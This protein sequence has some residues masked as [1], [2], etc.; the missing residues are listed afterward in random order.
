MSKSRTISKNG[1]ANSPFVCIIILLDVRSPA[2]GGVKQVSVVDEIKARL[3]IVAVVGETVALKKSGR[4]YTGFCP[5]H[6]NTRTPSFV[7]FPDSQT[8]RCFGACADG[9][10][11]FSFIMKREGLDFKEALQFLA[12]RAGVPLQAYA[13]SAEQSE[14]HDKLLDL[15]AAA[16]AYFHHLLTTSPA[17]SKTREYL[18]KRE[19]TGETIATFQ[20]G[21]ALDEWEALK[22][23]LI[24]RGYTAD[25]LLAAGLIVA[26]DDGAPGYDRF[27]HRLMIPIRDSKGRVIGFGARALSTD[28]VP[29]YLNSPQTAL[30][31]KSATL[32]GLDLARKSI[33][34]SGQ[35]VI[36]EGY[37]DTI[38][39]HQRGARNVVAQMGTALTE[40][41]L[42]L[43]A[44]LAQRI[45]LALDADTAGNSATVRSLSVA[46]QLLPKKHRATTTS[47]GVE[48]EAH[49]EQDIYIAALPAGQDPDDVLRA[50]LDVW[51]QFITQAVPALDFYEGLILAQADLKTPQ[52]KAFVVRELMPIYREVKDEVEK[53]ARVQ[54][55]ARKSGLDERLLLAELKSK[56]AKPHSAAGRTQ[57]VLPPEIPPAREEVMP[58]VVAEA[59]IRIGL[60]EYCLSMILATPLS[61]ALANEILEKQDVPGLNVNDFKHQENREIFRALQLWTVSETPQIEALTGMVGEVLERRLAALA[62][63]W[64]RRPPVPIENINQDLSMTILRLR[65]QNIDEQVKELELLQHQTNKDEEST[66][67]YTKVIE[68]HKQERNKLDRTR[69]ALTLMG[70]RRTEANRFGQAL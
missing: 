31:D 1:L 10:D 12:Q 67:Y 35:V 23:H 5:F 44:P 55:L 61:L 62:S 18:A 34:D 20:L 15:L 68:E 38:Q 70:Q 47:R 27:R 7:V 25:E 63:H 19:L 13:R 26:R 9:G 29:K 50:G 39:A 11:I 45:V 33:R 46:R 24:E 8:W 65:R 22:S 6:S 21:Y 14:Q 37:M 69:D 52:G 51:Q 2:E 48:Y 53:V 3:D 43:I 16:A 32:Y 58:P 4:S 66:R 42:K 17:G 30:F 41:Q 40:A 60:E 59:A 54:R 64:H 28:Q 49:I 57:P 36:V 56:P